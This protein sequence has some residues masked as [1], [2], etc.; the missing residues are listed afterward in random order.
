[1]PADAETKPVVPVFRHHGLVVSPLHEPQSP[2]R[3]INILVV[4]ATVDEIAHRIVRQG[5]VVAPVVVG[6]AG[7]ELVRHVVRTVVVEHAGPAPVDRAVEVELVEVPVARLRERPE[8]ATCER[9]E[10][11]GTPSRIASIPC[12]SEAEATRT[13]DITCFLRRID[14]R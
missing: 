7:R 14:F 13:K 5:V 2:E 9:L 11:V 6:V 10:I 8:F 3:I 1:M 4:L 12:V